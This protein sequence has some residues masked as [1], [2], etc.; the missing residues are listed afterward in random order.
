M[1]PDY[2][3]HNGKL[4]PARDFLPGD[5]WLDPLFLLHTEMWFAN[6]EIPLFQA[7]LYVWREIF[8]SLGK[9]FPV[10][11]AAEGEFMRHC[12]RLIN[13]NKAYM[14]GWL[15]MTFISQPDGNTESLVRVRH[16]P[17]RVFPFAETGKM[18]VFSPLVKLSGSPFSE[19]AFF[20]KHR[21]KTER[22]RLY[23]TKT[24]EP[25]FVNEKGILAEACGAN[26][27]CIRNNLLYTPSLQTGCYRD[28]IRDKVLKA[29]RALNLTVSESDSIFPED[30]MNMEEIF[31][32]S[33]SKGF[34]WIM[35]IET[36]RF[37]KTKT[38]QI[39]E[40]LNRMLTTKVS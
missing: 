32:V 39:W 19:Y 1:A 3:L 33:E 17:S 37:V 4:I 5:Q 15:R 16:H 8:G 2:I 6:G 36:R 12:L 38:V 31:T 20:S 30:L 40:E 18:A 25:F 35:G 10:D 22:F 14:G 27:Y 24:E 7:H 34:A 13:K 21:W 26:I 23:G 29:S 28:L 11:S 9:N